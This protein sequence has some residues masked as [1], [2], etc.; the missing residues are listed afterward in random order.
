[1]GAWQQFAV[2]VVAGGILSAI[3]LVFFILPD[4]NASSNDKSSAA[5]QLSVTSTL[6][7]PP[8]LIPTNTP[9]PEPTATLPPTAIPA[10][11]T[12]VVQPGDSLAAICAAEAPLALDCIN[13][14]VSLNGLTSP[15]QIA[16]GETLTLPVDDAGNPVSQETS[17]PTTT[18]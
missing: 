12:Y 13:A 3:A 16:V 17:V 15:D 7:P 9:T 6:A 8:T 11:K 18:P 1:M 5:T 4:D 2:G 14:V 10:P